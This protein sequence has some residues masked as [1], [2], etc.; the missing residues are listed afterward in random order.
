MIPN[1][2]TGRAVHHQR[3]VNI[4]PGE[5]N[6]SCDGYRYDDNRY[7]PELLAEAEGVPM[8]VHQKSGDVGD[9]GHGDPAKIHTRLEISN[10]NILSMPLKACR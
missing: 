5:E 9:G 1:R 7:R 3:V 2:S 4:I 6:A 8:A 10:S